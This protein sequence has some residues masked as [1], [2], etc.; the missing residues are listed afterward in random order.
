MSANSRAILAEPGKMVIQECERPTPGPNEVL[1]KIA[2]VGMCGSDIHGFKFGPYI[3]AQPGQIVGLGHEPAGVI[4]EV[5]SEVTRV[6]VGDRV[7]LEPGQP[8]H[9]CEFCLS[10]HYN[11]CPQMDFLATAPN[12]RGAFAEYMTHPADLVFVLPDDMTLDEGALVEPASVAAHAVEMTG[13]ILGKTVVI[14]GCGAVGLLTTMVAKIAGASKVV[15]VDVQEGRLEK[16]RELG[17]TAALNGANEDVVE[18]IR[19]IIGEYGADVVFETAG[20]IPTI[21]LA[22]QVIKRR[23]KLMVVGTIPGDAPIPFLKINREVEI[24]TVFRYCNTY[25]KTIQMIN[26]KALEASAI[27]DKHFAYEDI[28]EAFEFAANQPGA[29]TK[30]VVVVDPSVS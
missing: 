14:L 8:C 25:P 17:A 27:V 1:V 20:A 7:A 5:G 28:Q 4:A 12:Y 30:A 26:S 2:R 11:V 22:L 3:P 13:N 21:K 23:G 10:G 16:A 19:A 15:V 24:Q 18:Q 6:K 9:K 29:F